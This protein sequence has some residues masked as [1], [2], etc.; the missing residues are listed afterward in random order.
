MKKKKQHKYIITCRK[1]YIEANKLDKR[2]IFTPK[3]ED[4]KDDVNEL[5][6][7]LFEKGDI[8]DFIIE[9]CKIKEKLIKNNTLKEEIADEEEKYDKNVEDEKEKEWNAERYKKELNKHK[10]I[11]NWIKT[12]F[13]LASILEILPQIHNKCKKKITKYDICKALISEWTKRE[14]NKLKVKEKPEELIAFYELL[15]YKNFLEE[16]GIK[17]KG[18]N[19]TINKKL[20]EHA[21]VQYNEGSLSAYEFINKDI[22]TFL[23]ISYMIKNEQFKIYDLVKKL[24]EKMISDMSLSE[25]PKRDKQ[26]ILAQI[27]PHLIPTKEENESDVLLENYLTILKKLIAEY[28]NKTPHEIFKDGICVPLSLLANKG[29]PSVR[30]YLRKCKFE[31]ELQELHI[32]AALGRVKVCR[33]L[34]D[35]VPNLLEQTEALHIAARYGH[36]KVCELLIK[37]YPKLITQTDKKGETALQYAA[38]YGHSKIYELFINKYPELITQTDEL[39]DTALHQAAKKGHLEVCELLINKYPN[40]ITQTNDLGELALHIAAWQGHVEICKLLINKDPSLIK[41]TAEDSW[42]ALH[43]AA[44]EGHVEICKFLINKDPL[45]PNYTTTGGDYKGYN[46]YQIAA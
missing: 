8:D 22:R 17:V 44:G 6:V 43:Y 3:K 36:L 12:P 10:A 19:I 27:A 32:A 30:K 16:Q 7:R 29:Y 40:F 4:K 25:M 14:T 41:Q 38:K 23:V 2:E 42:T 21:P 26:N 34:I 5:Q 24:D 39:G 28:L 18:I 35:K 11:K 20:L 45:L 1:E 13:I 31:S 9:F 37:A 46:A 15:A 33:I